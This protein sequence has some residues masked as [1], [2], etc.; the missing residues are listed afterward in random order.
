MTHLRHRA[1][2]PVKAAAYCKAPMRLPLAALQ[3]LL[4]HSSAVTRRHRGTPGTWLGLR[5]FLTEGSSTLTPD[6]PA[7]QKEFGQPQGQK[8]GRGFPICTLLGLF[9]AFT[10]RVV[11]A[12]GFE[13][14]THEPS[15]V[16]KPHPLL[17]PGDGRVGDRG[18]C[19]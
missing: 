17:G 8:P 4:L 9:D 19:S 12:L 6:T 7:L 14:Y 2:D 11:E 1:K 16:G 18:F 13:L 5:A 3:A 15:K 10:G